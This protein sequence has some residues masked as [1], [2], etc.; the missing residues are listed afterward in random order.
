MLLGRPRAQIL[1]RW[2]FEVEVTSGGGRKL[3]RAGKYSF[4]LD[5]TVG[6]CRCVL[7]NWRFGGLCAVLFSKVD[8]QRLL[9]RVKNSELWIFTKRIRAGIEPA[10]LPYK[11]G[12]LTA[13]PSGSI[14][15]GPILESCPDQVD[16]CLR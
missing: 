4:A 9:Q 1:G 15:A 14:K 5:R 10:T 2:V 13:S 8:S 12:V 6:K 7:Q 11:T 16:G 3:H